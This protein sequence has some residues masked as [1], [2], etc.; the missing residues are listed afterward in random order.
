[1]MRGTNNA[2]D[3][4]GKD[5]GKE[6]GQR[7]KPKREAIKKRQERLNHEMKAMHKDGVNKND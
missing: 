1:M 5:E 7:I 6:K 2:S 4:T 3:E